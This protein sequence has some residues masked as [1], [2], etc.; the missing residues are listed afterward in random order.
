MRISE[1]AH[2][3]VMQI[4]TMR[5]QRTVYYLIVGMKSSSTLLVYVANIDVTSIVT[6]GDSTTVETTLANST[7]C[8]VPI[9]F[10]VLRASRN[11]HLLTF[12]ISDARRLFHLLMVLILLQVAVCLRMWEVLLIWIGLETATHLVLRLPVETILNVYALVVAAIRMV[13]FLHACCW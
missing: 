12:S 4:W 13:H 6:A 11:W 1:V 3:I 5:R 2:F 10:G 8:N 7:S 9:A